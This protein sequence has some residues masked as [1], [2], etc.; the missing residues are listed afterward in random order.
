VTPVQ[1]DK[2]R[3]LMAV[4]N[5]LD[6]D[7]RVQRAAQA[8]SGFADVEVFAIEGRPGFKPDGDYRLSTLPV[9]AGE[10]GS[11]RM[12]HLRF[13]HALVRKARAL[14]P[15]FLYAH[16]FFLATPGWIAARASGARFVYDAHELVIPG[17]LGRD[18]AQLQERVWYW[19]ERFAVRR[20]DLV[21]AANEARARVM[22]EHYGLTRQ[23]TSIRNITV[24]PA[25]AVPAHAELLAQFPYLARREPNECLCVYQGDVDLHRGLKPVVDAFTRL[26]PRYRLLVVGG[27]PDVEN[28]RTRAREFGDSAR[29]EVVGKVPRAALH[30]ILSGCDIG[31]CVYAYTGL[32]NIYCSPNKVFEYAQA[33]LAVVATGQPPLVELVAD[34][35]IGRIA[36][37]KAPPSAEELADAIRQAH[38]G[39]EGHK[40]ALAGFLAGNRWQDEMQRLRTAIQQLPLAGA[41][42]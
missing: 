15:D 28:L 25:G 2:P 17:A 41:G 37:V 13:W 27:G 22:Q 4:F 20:A 11:N 7:G 31:I 40:A 29:V 32:N 9:R 19:L 35:S 14:H 38:A 16:D 10:F 30:G 6:F 18:Y 34:S 3:I 21:I 24:P 1:F 8:L 39:I 36:G 26:G 33:G 23:P 12:L 42:A 5:P